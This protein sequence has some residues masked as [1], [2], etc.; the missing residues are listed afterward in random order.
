MSQRKL[1]LIDRLLCEAESVLNTLGDAGHRASRESPAATSNES[2]LTPQERRH[3]AGL[4]RVNHTGEV[5]AQALYQGQALTARLPDVREQMEQA[6]Q[7]EID[8]R[9]WCEE[10]LQGSSRHSTMASPSCGRHWWRG[11]TR[12]TMPT[13][14]ACSACWRA[15]R[16]CSR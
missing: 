12:T 2:D 7:E 15:S 9:A 8:H 4:M 11:W 6:A 13:L 1:S 14:R 5:C 3:V 10:R 16:R